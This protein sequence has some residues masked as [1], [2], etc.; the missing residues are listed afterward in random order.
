MI[1][2][3]SGD[4]SIEIRKIGAAPLAASPLSVSV[5]GGPRKAPGHI[6]GGTYYRGDA[7]IEIEDLDGGKVRFNFAYLSGETAQTGEAAGVVALH[8]GV[9]VFRDRKCRLRLRFGTPGSGRLKVEEIEHLGCAFGASVSAAGEYRL[10]G[11]EAVEDEPP[12]SE[13]DH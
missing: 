6:Y 10:C 5:T 7:E 11:K 4:Y 2:P 9:G 12:A 1:L 3:E 13:P 8:G